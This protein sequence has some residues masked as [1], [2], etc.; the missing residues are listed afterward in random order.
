MVAG[1]MII[2]CC[3]VLWSSGCSPNNPGPPMEGTMDHDANSRVFTVKTHSGMVVKTEGEQGYLYVD[4][5]G[6]AEWFG[7]GKEP[8]K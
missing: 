8:T 2:P 4:D 6:K 7:P 1:M 5:S 3:A